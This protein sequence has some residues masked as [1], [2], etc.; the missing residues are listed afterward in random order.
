M[1]R[2]ILKFLASLLLY[3]L[4]VTLLL[5]FVSNAG[6]IFQNDAAIVGG[7]AFVAGLLLFS[8]RRFRL[9]PVY[10]FG[11]EMTHYLAAKLFR[12]KTGRIHIGM[13]EGYVEIVNANIWTILAP[14]F[15]PF[16]LVVAMGVLGMTQFFWYPTPR[17]GVLIFAAAVGLTYAYHCVMT[18]VAISHTQ[19][20][21]ARHGPV[22]SLSL[23]LTCNAFFLL[24]AMMLVTGRWCAT[25]HAFSDLALLQFQWLLHTIQRI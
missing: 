7:I 10:V 14:Y 23:I 4:A 12:L 15:V 24:L 13:R 9:E 5:T 18:T 21:L 16:Y 25:W 22:F 2:A 3:W 8:C 19:S 20:D 6:H 1:I 17:E 11:H